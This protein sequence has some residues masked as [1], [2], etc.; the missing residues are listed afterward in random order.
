MRCAVGGTV[1]KFG[2]L[3][4]HGVRWVSS[5]DWQQGTLPNWNVCSFLKSRE[6]IL[7]R[8]SENLTYIKIPY[9]AY[10]DFS[11]SLLFEGLW[12]WIL[13]FWSSCPMHP[14]NAH[15]CP[16]LSFHSPIWACKIFR[17]AC[18]YRCCHVCADMDSRVERFGFTVGSHTNHHVPC[19]S[20][21][22]EKIGRILVGWI[23]K[24]NDLQLMVIENKTSYV[25]FNFWASKFHSQYFHLV[26][27]HPSLCL[28][29]HFPS[30]HFLST[31]WKGKRNYFCRCLKK[32]IINR[33]YIIVLDTHIYIHT[34]LTN[35]KTQ[36]SMYFF[37]H[38]TDSL[39][40]RKCPH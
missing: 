20:D 6:S 16:C 39:I 21:F 11:N 4:S 2:P 38:F 23:F 33:W 27:I 34:S 35:K 30:F 24:S 31:L 32:L 13:Q 9:N 15:A 10:G 28:P 36:S 14:S 1:A 22:T 5:V 25:S 26:L 8:K 17:R 29:Y 19:F 12:A 7:S 18:V 37:F 40:K 3:F